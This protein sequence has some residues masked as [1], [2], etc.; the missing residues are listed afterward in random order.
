MT[1]LYALPVAIALG[2]GLGFVLANWIWHR[3]EERRR[4]EALEPFHEPIEPLSAEANDNDSLWIRLGETNAV[5]AAAVLRE[6]AS[7]KP[8]PD[9]AE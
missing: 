1:L 7:P 9:A 8:L 3:Q 2:I 4:E 6:N 5:R